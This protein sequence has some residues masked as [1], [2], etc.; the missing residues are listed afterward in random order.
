MASAAENRGNLRPK[1]RAAYA[2]AYRAN[3]ENKAAIQKRERDHYHSGGGKAVRKARHEKWKAERPLDLRVRGLRAAVS[4]EIT[5][6]WLNAKWSDQGGKCALSG[7]DLDMKFEVDHIV[8]RSRGGGDDLSNLRLVCKAANQA[9][10][11]L[12]DDEFIALCRDIVG[13]H[14]D[15]D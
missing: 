7:R 11:S 3:P 10:R 12:L 15:G 13:R 1:S 14:Q 6:D 5:L 2:R 9:K 4:S 8:P